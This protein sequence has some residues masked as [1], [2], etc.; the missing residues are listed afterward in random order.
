ML[1]EPLNQ[2]PCGCRKGQD[3]IRQGK[4]DAWLLLR[5]RELE[6]PRKGT[7]ASGARG[8]DWAQQGVET[9]RTRAS[10]GMETGLCM[11]WLEM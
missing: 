8:A 1:A 3:I 11:V 7:Q 5:Q 6:G 4:H 10:K 9:E 2:L